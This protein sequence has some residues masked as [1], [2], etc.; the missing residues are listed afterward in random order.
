LYSK[1]A[2][3]Y[4]KGKLLKKDKKRRKGSKRWTSVLVIK[5]MGTRC[6]PP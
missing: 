2:C 4:A 6:P 1:D 5:T 3:G